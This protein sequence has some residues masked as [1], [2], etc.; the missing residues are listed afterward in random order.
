MSSK[1]RAKFIDH[2]KFCGL[3][4]ET[5]RSYITGVK[6]LARHYHQSPVKLTDDQ[7]RAYFHHLITERKLQWNSCHTYLS[8]IL[9][10]YR[11]IC[12]REVDDRYGLPPQPR[13]T[14][15]PVVLS[16]EE[17]AHLF[18][19]VESLKYRV[20][21][22]TIYSAGLR[23]KEAVSLKPVHIESD[24]SR[25]VIR[26]EQGKGRKDRYTVLSKKL[27]LELRE[28]WCKYSPQKWLFAGQKPDSHITTNAVW[29]AF[30]DAKKKAGIKKQCSPHTL[31][32]CFASHLLYKGYDLYTISQLL[33]HSSIKTT[34]IYL[35]ITPA[36]YVEL[37]SPL[38]FIQPQKEG[39]DDDKE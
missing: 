36:R 2:M 4:K 37:K 18:T 19:C 10:F 26:V 31:R 27:L 16:M 39:Q 22:K 34:T 24:P 11:Q 38:D 33:G 28:Y 20:I 7:V 29:Y 5:Q 15:L 35:H 1:I 13:G 21:L 6:G 12:N 8:G 3:S 9:L 25:M 32:H 14:K 23:I 30:D 17:V